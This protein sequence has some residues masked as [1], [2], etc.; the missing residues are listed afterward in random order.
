MKASPNLA[1]ERPKTSLSRQRHRLMHFGMLA[2]VSCWAANMVAIKEALFGFSPL[3]LAQVRALFTALLF[4]ILFLV[5]GR[6]SSLRI[7]RRRWPYFVLMALCGITVGQILFIRAISLTS[8]SHAALIVAM[9]PIMVL[10]LSV[11]M[12]FEPLTLLKALGMAISFLGVLVLT[13]ARSAQGNHA[14]WLG[15]VL[16]LV[17]ILIFSYYTIL[18]KGV[19]DQYD[20]LALNTIVF[21]LGALMMLPYGAKAVWQ[22]NWGQIP[23]RSVLGLAFMVVFSS[24]VAYLLFAYALSG[25]TAS[26]VAAFNY[27]EPIFATALGIWLLADKVSSRGILGGALIL[28]GVYFTEQERGEDGGSKGLADLESKSEIKATRSRL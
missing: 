9:G 2:A 21:G 28:I 20:P 3:A 26:R 4:G 23:F 6:A 1:A 27:L 19:A 14:H 11:L 15:D 7:S 16:L 17:Q 18:M 22:V 13:F 8:V 5:F 12:R 25:L 24:V 10:I